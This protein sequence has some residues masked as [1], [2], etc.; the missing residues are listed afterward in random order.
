LVYVSGT[1]INLLV[2][3]LIA[4]ANT[5]VTVVRETTRSAAAPAVVVAVAPGMFEIVLGAERRGAITNI[6]G[7]LVTAGAPA[8]PGQVLSMY[9]TGLGASD[10][11]PG[12]PG[13]LTSRVRPQVIVDGRAA[14]VQFAGPSPSFPGLDQI[15]FVV[16]PATAGAREV[17]LWVEQADRKSNTVV[18]PIR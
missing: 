4:G 8:T 17:E 6:A 9:L 7:A 2:P 13:L 5:S 10:P 1:Q 18:L 3:N 16:P 15:N 11:A 12:S 14:E